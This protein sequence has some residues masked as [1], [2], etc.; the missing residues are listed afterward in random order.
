M[1]EWISVKDKLPDYD[2]R[3]MI[4]SPKYG[5]GAFT[6]DSDGIDIAVATTEYWGKKDYRLVWHSDGHTQCDGEEK[7][8]YDAGEVTHWM[9]LPDLPEI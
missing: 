6:D 9:P 7:L 8:R 5:F 1:S 4:F 3:V 2:V